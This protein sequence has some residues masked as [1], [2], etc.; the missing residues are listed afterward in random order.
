MPSILPILRARRERRIARRRERADRSRSFLL[1]AGMLLS[2]LTA[3]LLLAAAFLYADLT[4]S[5]PS[6]Q[7]IPLLLNP[8]DGLL[9]Q[10]TRITDRTGEH[11]LYT[12]APSDSPRRYIPLGETNPQ[13]LPQALADAVIARSDP[14][15]WK[16]AGYNLTSLT[17]YQLHDT[18]AQRLVFDLLL[19]NEPP[20]LRRALRER[21][22]AAQITAEFGRTQILEWYLNSANFGRYAFGAE[23][24]AQLY[25]GKSAAE[26]TAAEA[27]I[28]AAV[29][30]APSLN[31]HDAPQ[32]AL[33]RGEE[34]IRKMSALGLLSDEATANALG[35]SPRFQPPPPTPPQPAP[36][37]VNLLL[38]QLDSQFPRE[39]IERGGLTIISTLDF[40]LQK[41]ASCLTAFYAAR[42]AGLPDPLIECDALRYLPALPPGLTSADS[43]ASAIITD[44]KKGQV[45]ALVGE[46]FQAQ[47]TP[48][49]GAHSPGSSLDAFVY[50]TAF[51]R[52]LS[53]AS[54][55][56]DIPGKTSV[57]NFD[58]V[59]HGP[60]RL[61]VA[62]AND[63]PAPAAQVLAQMGAE[64]VTKIAESFGVSRDAP[65]SLWKAAGAY[66]VFA[67]NGVYFGQNVGGDFVPVTI[68]RVEGGDGSVWLDWSTPQVKPVVTP[69][70]AYLVNH[71]LS[72]ETART[73]WLRDTRL[74][75]VDRPAAVKLGQTENGFD[76]WT[77]GY[78]PLRVVAVWTGSRADTKLSPRAPATLWKALMQAASQNLPPEDWA[79]PLEVSVVNVCDPSGM[80]PTPDCPNIVNEVFLHGSEPQ[81]A[82]TMYRRF[83]VNRETNLLATV[84]T[85]P[86]LIEERVYLVVPPEARAW[87]EGAGLA[88]PP[89]AYDVIQAPPFN[90]D[91]NIST[92][93]LFAEVS[94]T[95]RIE[96]TA[97]G[98]DFVSY[99]VLVGQGLDPR[100]WIQIGEG[101]EAV[102]NGLLAE[103]DT[104]GISG[105]Y[106]V[107]LQVIR[108]DQRVDTAII[109]VTV[110]QR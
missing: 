24:A 48:L 25:F 30:D 51:T 81:H 93:A 17:N 34:T 95:V 8:P 57:Q 19:F 61:R 44:P 54:L 74:L 73:G 55:I 5:L 98:A 46:T 27:A 9:L 21:L 92:P 23:A 15:F 64:N 37:F 36:A 89:S 3:A 4:R 22:L 83:A 29:S 42:L 85:L 66:G 101:T 16:H 70:L 62:L 6:P 38:A 18:L 80:L 26:L 72:D 99:R 69:G 58:G 63:Y 28:L 87:A 43:S 60:M 11:T 90:P 76:T 103:W 31:P 67:Q 7:L 65:V 106:A 56:W 14:N 100:E 10:P 79:L 1:S 49:V 102:A 33:E 71:S 78:S 110:T 20:S 53:P 88:I 107:Q 75:E 52:G 40:D 94:G 47:E 108:S 82:D 35:E 32:T 2:L 96:G 68:L 59:H 104:S 77:I 45:L 50:L 41:Q 97:A 105:L 86:Q 39:R 12:F 91:V 109:Q 13:R 84:F